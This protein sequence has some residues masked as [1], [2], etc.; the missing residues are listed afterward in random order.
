[1][2][3][4]KIK[5]FF[6]HLG[7][8]M[9][10][11]FS[12]SGCGLNATGGGASSPSW[13]FRTIDTVG[14]APCSIAVDTSGRPHISYL[15]RESSSHLAYAYFNGS[16][17]LTETIASGVT[18]HDIAIDGN[19]LPHICYRQGDNLIHSHYTGSIWETE[20][21]RTGV[22]PDHISIA[23]DS[24]EAIHVSYYNSNSKDLAYVKKTVSW[25]AP[26]VIDGSGDTTSE[27]G[28][29]NSIALDNSDNPH[30]SYKSVNSLKHAQWNVSWSTETVTNEAASYTSLA[31]DNSN[32]PLISYHETSAL[33]LKL[34][35]YSGSTWSTETVDAGGIAGNS[36]SLNI[37]PDGEI[38]ILYI[39]DIVYVMH[40]W[41]SGLAWEFETVDN[42]EHVASATFGTIKIFMAYINNSL[43][44]AEFR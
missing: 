14:Y 34:A 19:N 43:K 10:V 3:N 2:I 30:I 36:S 16:N 28:S 5:S 24:A 7:L 9:I 38:H 18:F 31:F 41:N 15:G 20:T 8:L 21:A 33:D 44:Y 29:Y 6:H 32:N 4:I 11:V 17:W 42:G 39:K 27:V 37:D 12:V 26:T 22:Y 23:I 25:S 1:M 13:H 40:A 35:R